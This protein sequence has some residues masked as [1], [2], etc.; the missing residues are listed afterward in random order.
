MTRRCCSEQQIQ[1]ALF[2]HLKWRGVP[3]LFAFHCPTGGWRSAIEAAIFKGIGVVA[4]IPDVLIIH[5]G[6]CYALELKTANGRL[7]DVQ[8]IAHERLREAGAHVATVYGIDE[9]LAQLTEWRLLRGAV[10]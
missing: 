8:R 3:G 9:A 7:T 6:G 1:C 2:D 10:L 5:S 4:G